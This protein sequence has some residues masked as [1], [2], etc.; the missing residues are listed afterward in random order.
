MFI[1]Q[2]PTKNIE[3]FNQAL[4][5]N[6][7]YKNIKL[8]KVHTIILIQDINIICLKPF[9]EQDFCFDEILNIVSFIIY[10]SWLSLL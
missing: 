5:L 6:I 7:Y 4:Q 10:S 2:P 8:F 9:M 3:W 1:Y